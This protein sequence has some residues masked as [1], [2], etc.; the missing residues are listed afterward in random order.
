MGDGLR[1]RCGRSH[2]GIAGLLT[3]P[4]GGSRGLR[5]WF[6]GFGRE[7]RCLGFGLDYRRSQP[8]IGLWRRDR[9]FSDRVRLRLFFLGRRNIAQNNERLCIWLHFFARF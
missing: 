8:Q 2:R 1:I 7:G 3:R 9:D 5:R 4:F 6:F